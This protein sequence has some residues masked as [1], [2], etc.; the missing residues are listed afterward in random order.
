MP[1]TTCISPAHSAPGWYADP[2]G[3]GQR[4]WNGQSWMSM[5]RIPRASAASKS[6]DCGWVSLSGACRSP[7]G[8]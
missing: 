5:K 3:H 1:P 6:A 2:D 4:Y 7:V 8:Y